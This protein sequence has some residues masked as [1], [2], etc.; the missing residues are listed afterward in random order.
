LAAAAAGAWWADPDGGAFD[1][2][3]FRR[4]SGLPCPGCGLTRSV[5]AMAQG[6]WRLALAFHPFGPLVLGWAIAA[7]GTPLLGGR[8][9][10]RGALALTH[11][12]PGFDRAYGTVLAAF[13]GF[14]ALR[15]LGVALGIWPTSWWGALF[16]P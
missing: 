13:I 4:F 12:R 16:R 7:S 9:R 15:L 1:L 6:D 11:A 8:A 2:C 10:R 14:G 5:V 3:Y